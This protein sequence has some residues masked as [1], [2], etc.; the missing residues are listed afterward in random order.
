ALMVSSNGFNP[1]EAIFY[2]AAAGAGFMLSSFMFVE[3]K[4]Q[5]EYS[6]IPEFLKGLPILLITAG[7]IALVF[8]GFHGMKFM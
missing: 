3:I 2:G 5:L 7:L 6:E 1:L 8:T 4:K